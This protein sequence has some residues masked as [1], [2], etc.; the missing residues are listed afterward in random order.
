MDCLKVREHLSE[1]IDNLLDTETTRLLEEHVLTCKGCKEELDSLQKM[2][3]NLRSLELIKAPA[4]LLINLNQRIEKRSA[5]SKIFNRLFATHIFGLRPQLV[6]PAAIILLILILVSIF[7]SDVPK[8]IGP[9]GGEIY[10]ANVKIIIPPNAVTDKTKISIRKQQDLAVPLAAGSSDWASDFYDINKS[11]PKVQFQVPIEIIIPSNNKYL[12]SNKYYFMASWN[13]KSWSRLIT[14]TDLENTAFKGVT[15]HLSKFSVFSSKDIN[16]QNSIDLKIPRYEQYCP[17]GSVYS[18]ASMLL[19]AYGIKVEPKDVANDF[20]SRH[21][22]KG[23][24]NLNNIGGIIDEIIEFR[25]YLK[26]RTSQDVLAMIYTINK[27]SSS[28]QKMRFKQELKLQISDNDPVWIFAYFKNNQRESK[29]YPFVMIGYDEESIKIHD[30]SGDI[31]KAVSSNKSNSEESMGDGIKWNDFLNL[32]DD[33]TVY[34]LS[35]NN[36]TK[37]SDVQQAK[38]EKDP[39]VRITQPT[40]S[41]VYDLKVKWDTISLAGTA[42]DDTGV[43]GVAW[44]DS[45]RRSGIASGTTNW[46]ITNID[47]CLDEN[48]RMIITVGAVDAEKNVGIDTLTVSMD[49]SM[50]T[51]KG[52]VKSRST[53]RGADRGASVVDDVGPAAPKELSIYSYEPIE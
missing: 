17:G 20:E 48:H 25:D 13:G 12:V 44:S 41:D 28:S 53:S 6:A 31:A 1:Y 51:G 50:G 40:T 42:S 7:V 11:D 9:D 52:D 45:C 19:N 46:T 21:C 36:A 29:A 4:N 22:N 30:P 24:S 2:V 26:A 38:D 5:L 3:S 34:T 8:A 32:L 33:A 18:C 14:E 49:T 27:Q 15:T 37:L 39:L 16:M 10:Q 23:L 47:I 43:V 35:I